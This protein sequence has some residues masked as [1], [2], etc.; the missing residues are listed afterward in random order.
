MKGAVHVY[1]RK[2]QLVTRRIADESIIV[3]VA[4]NVGD[5]ESVYTMGEV[6]AYI[7]ERLDGQR[8]L[9]EIVAGICLEYEIDEVSAKSD[10]A[11]FISAL[12]IAGLIEKV[13][14]ESG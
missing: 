11:E 14:G 7:W 4:E 13:R 10:A 3:P 5:L 9:D 8:P 6:G 1:R 12:E 2:E